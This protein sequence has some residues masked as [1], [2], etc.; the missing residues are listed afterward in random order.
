LEKAGLEMEK[1]ELRQELEKRQKA[2]E[3]YEKLHEYSPAGY[4]TFCAG[5]KITEV[6]L[7]G[8]DMLKHLKGSLV[9]TLFSAF[10]H[11][12]DRGVFEAHVSRVIER[13]GGHTCD[14]RLK[15]SDGTFF[16]ALLESSAT[17]EKGRRCCRTSI[18]DVTERKRGEEHLLALCMTDELTGLYNR[19][20]FFVLAEQQIKLANRSGQRMVL[21]S[22][23][24]DDFKRIN[25]RFGHAEGDS[26]L[27]E[28]A[29]LLRG[30]VRESDVVSRLGGDEFVILQSADAQAESLVSRLRKNLAIFNSERHR[31]Y[32]ISLSIGVSHYDPSSPSSLVR[33][34]ADADK[35][36]Y[37][38]KMNKRTP[39]GKITDGGG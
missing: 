34:L 7:T 36:M 37:E 26:V 5:G 20:G 4:F 28:T 31:P 12:E 21:L 10:V 2:S 33:I 6:N 3:R 13:E 9:G 38:E 14:L 16:H 35:A 8:A 22:A 32:E 27:M 25:D 29:S 1:E 18:I 19:R 24:L 30:T 23:D 17:D 15:R 11:A 39:S